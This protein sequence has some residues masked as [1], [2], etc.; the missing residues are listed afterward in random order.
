MK[1]LNHEVEVRIHITYKWR[2]RKWEWQSLN[3]AI[4]KELPHIYELPSAGI[5]KLI[6]V[7]FKLC[8]NN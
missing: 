5:L 4:A 3:P 7:K 2:K 6:E 1:K 8:N